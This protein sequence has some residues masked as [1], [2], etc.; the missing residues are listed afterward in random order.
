MSREIDSDAEMEELEDLFSSVAVRES[1]FDEKLA[2]DLE[3]H[4]ELEKELD[5]FCSLVKP[6]KAWNWTNVAISDVNPYFFTIPFKSRQGIRIQYPNVTDRAI[7]AFTVDRNDGDIFDTVKLTVSQASSICSAGIS[8]MNLNYVKSTIDD[9]DV[10][11]V[12]YVPNKPTQRALPSFLEKPCKLTAFGCIKLGSNENADKAELQVICA[13]HSEKLKEAKYGVALL[14]QALCATVVKNIYFRRVLTARA[15]HARLV[16]YYIRNGWKFGTETVNLTSIFRQAQG[17]PA[18]EQIQGANDIKFMKVLK[19][20]ILE[21]RRTFEL[22]KRDVEDL[23]DAQTYGVILE[24]DTKE[25]HDVFNSLNV[26]QYPGLATLQY[27]ALQR[28]FDFLHK[29]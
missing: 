10:I 28:L 24:T 12:V 5:S 1:S 9:C 14:C 16:S 7:V 4:A 22:S 17:V 23:F 8:K 26:D 11:V 2:L 18:Y 19:A 25:L 21:N 13:D 29:K 15:I 6:P 3:R 20:Y 27:N